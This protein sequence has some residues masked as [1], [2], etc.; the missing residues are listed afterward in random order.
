MFQTLDTKNICHAVYEDGVFHFDGFETASTKTWS[1]HHATDKEDMQVASIW[2]NGGSLKDCCP[3]DVMP[4]YLE[5][6]KKLQAFNMAFSAVDFNIEEWCIYDFMPLSFLIDLCEVKNKITENVLQNYTKPKSYDH[7]LGVHRLLSEMNYKDVLFDFDVAAQV[8]TTRALQGKLRS[9]RG[10]NKWVHYDPYGTITGRLS[11]KPG[12]FPILNLPHEFKT[13]V[14]PHNDLF[15]ELDFNAAELRTMLALA[16]KEQPEEDIHAWNM[17][18][19]FSRIDNRD[20]AKKKAFQWLYGKTAANKTL[21]KVYDKEK[22]KLDWFHHDFVKTP[23]GRAIEC[24][25]DHAINYVIQSTTADVVYE[26]SSKVAK[27]LEDRQTN[28]AFIVHDCIVL[29]LSKKDFDLIDDMVHSFSNTRFGNFR[30][31]LKAGKTYG[32]LKEISL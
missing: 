22:I 1:Y 26:S 9:L 4:G 31:S 30:T 24:D 23:Y 8:S 16:G 18:N 20:H 7:L 5:I 13:A 28:I 29:D 15:V 32:G 10:V 6:E 3:A 12:S 14:R 19:V 11:T 2:A 21:E 27:L 17:K 25:E